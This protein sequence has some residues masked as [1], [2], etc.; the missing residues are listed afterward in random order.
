MGSTVQQIIVAVVSALLIAWLTAK[1]FK[2]TAAGQSI[3]RQ[4]TDK[5]TVLSSK[6]LVR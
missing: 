2:D 4:V 1:F 3:A 6:D 5:A